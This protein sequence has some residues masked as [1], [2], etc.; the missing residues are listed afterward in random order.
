MT[1]SAQIEKSIQ[2]TLTDNEE[3]ARKNSK[4]KLLMDLQ[5]AYELFDQI[6]TEGRALLRNNK[7]STTS[8][9]IVAMADYFLV[10]VNSL[11]L[12]CSA[13]LVQSLQNAL[14]EK[15]EGENGSHEENLAV[16]EKLCQAAKSMSK[17]HHTFLVM[18]ES[19]LPVLN[20]LPK[21]DEKQEEQFNADGNV[22]I[23]SY[24]K[25]LHSALT[26]GRA[27]QQIVRNSNQMA[28]LSK[29]LPIQNPLR[30]FFQGNLSKQVLEPRK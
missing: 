8:D 4:N 28:P 7:N 15:K 5:G 22:S 6:F 27:L 16:Q 23:P 3:T 17:L 25:D 30:R 1:K 18:V 13:E 26:V 10:L 11:V 20:S 12:E 24:N 14:H 2:T 9:E 29:S 19:S 21:N